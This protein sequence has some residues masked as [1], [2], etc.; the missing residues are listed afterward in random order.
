MLTPKVELLS[1]T[2]NA[3]KLIETA[4]RTSYMSFDKQGQDSE[5]RF[6]RM[7]VKSG[8]HSVLEHAYATFRISGASRSFTHQLVRHRLCSFIQQSQ[9]YV[10][11]SK[12]NY[13][14]PDSIKNN[15]KAHSIFIDFMSKAKETYVKL[16]GLKIKKEDAR[17]VLPNAVESQIVVSA[18]FREW[19]NIIDLR[20]KAQAQWEIR[21]VA[22]EILKILKKHA[23][24]VFGD[25][26]IDEEKE[27]ITEV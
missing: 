10:D 20:G 1:I 17:Y 24:N 23:P 21:R 16:N 22:I 18:N 19:R 3:E 2:P 9:R 27:I 4:G 7:L 12:F 6:I 13:I 8:H 5:K 15:P 26:E 14:E 11:E 25:F